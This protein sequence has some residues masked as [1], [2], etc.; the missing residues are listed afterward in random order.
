VILTHT[1]SLIELL[2]TGC[3]TIGLFFNCKALARA[4][5]DLL[6]VKIR[7]INSIREYAAITTMSMF[8]AMV[9]VQV[10][11]V[12]DG[13]L[14]MSI[15]SPNNHV[16]PLS[17]VITSSFILCSFILS[18]LAYVQDKRRNN[19]IEMIKQAEDLENKG[20]TSG[21]RGYDK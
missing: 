21:R 1:I 20:E 2:W 3:C 7:R 5:G 19:I 18:L 15:P 4:A 14:A 17:Y 13:A 16:Q 11:F 10:V 9:I 6:A 12:I 8:I